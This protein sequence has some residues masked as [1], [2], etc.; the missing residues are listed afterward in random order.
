MDVDQEDCMGCIEPLFGVLNDSLHHGMAFYQ[1]NYTA[2]AIAQQRDRTAAN[3]VYDHGYHRLKEQLD[4]S[5]GCNFLQVR[6]LEV[7]NYWDL[8]VIRLKKVN[9]AG[10][11]RNYLT[12]QQRDFDDQ[13]P[14]VGLPAAAVRLV[15]GYQPDAAF[16]AID[17]VIVSRPLGKTIRWTAQIV[18]VDQKLSWIDITPARL[19]GTERTDFDSS[20]RRH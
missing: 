10:R 1:Q 7:L 3:C 6:G 2:E 16:T 12:Q 14:L 8:A 4:Q 20:R 19:S 17:R 15:V 11:W 18:I 9:G 13:L 5:S